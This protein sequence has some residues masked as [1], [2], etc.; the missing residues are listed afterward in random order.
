MNEKMHFCYLSRGSTHRCVDS[1]Q[2]LDSRAYV[3]FD[4]NILSGDK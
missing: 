3:Y 1:T 4:I 2:K